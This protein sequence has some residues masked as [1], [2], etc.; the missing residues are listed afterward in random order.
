MGQFHLLILLWSFT[1]I[2]GHIISV[3]TP[4]LVVWRTVI[5]SLAFFLWM[6]WSRPER[7]RVS[8][9]DLPIL[10]RN[11]ALLGLHWLC[12]FAAIASSNVS[13][14]LAGLASTS[15]FTALLEPVLE[16]RRIRAGEVLLGIFVLGGLL[17]IAR[18]EWELAR[19]GLGFALAGALLAVLYS[20]L[21]KRVVTAGIPSTTNMFYGMLGACALCSTI[22]AIVP[23]FSFEMPRTGDWVPLLVLSLGCTFLAYIWYAVLMK[24]LTPYTTNLAINFEPIYGII[25][26]AFFFREYENLHGTFYLG[27]A[28]IVFANVL[29]AWL[30]RRRR[31][32][33]TVRD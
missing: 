26:A 30:G 6:R 32:P 22:V 23:E 19:N 4:S 21:N 31:L 18:V 13:V 11:G 29:H 27:T 33:A 3:T 5:A 17:L 10:L 1:G 9:A 24:D 2:L 8:R 14:G 25:L 20:I 28:V 16:K 12:F 15:L 7:L